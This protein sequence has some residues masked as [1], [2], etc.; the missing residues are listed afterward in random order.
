MNTTSGL[1]HPHKCHYISF[2]DY[3]LSLFSFAKCVFVNLLCYFLF[4]VLLRYKDNWFKCKEFKEKL[5]YYIKIN[6]CCKIICNFNLISTFTTQ[7][8][9][10]FYFI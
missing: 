1:H 3:K 6:C 5:K 10:T 7:I 9:I 4:T 2:L 8:E